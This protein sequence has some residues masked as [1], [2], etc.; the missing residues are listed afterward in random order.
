[1]EF[2]IKRRHD[3]N[4]NIKRKGE[5]SLLGPKPPIRP[6][7]PL[8]CAAHFYIPRAPT[9]GPHRADARARPR[10]RSLAARQ[11]PF[12]S[13]P[14]RLSRR[15]ASAFS[16]PLTCGPASSAPSSTESRAWWESPP[17]LARGYRSRSLR[18]SSTLGEIKA[19]ILGRLAH[20][21]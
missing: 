14:P 15:S 12:A 13:H 16:R 5:I 1:L 20:L 19:G 6:N 8:I 18:S 2:K 21:P 7:S 9:L 4:K 10:I 3:R 17:H 11:A